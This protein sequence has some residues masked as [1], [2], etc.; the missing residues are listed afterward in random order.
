MMA[1]KKIQENLTKSLLL[2]IILDL[3][4]GQPMCGYQ[5][6]KT[7]QET[8]GV[9]FGASTIYPLLNQLNEK[10]L[11]HNEW[12]IKSRR[13]K[14]VFRLTQQGQQELDSTRLCI[15]VICQNLCDINNKDETN[16]LRVV[17]A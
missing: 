14:K 3:L 2:P 5:I 16:N 9:K 11:V 17:L 6:I 15:R 1:T 7:I 10:D 13:P 8:Y 12:E 4:N